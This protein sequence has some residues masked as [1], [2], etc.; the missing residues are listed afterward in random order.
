MIKKIINLLQENINRDYK[1]A[2]SI[3][4]EHTP[5]YLFLSVLDWI[6]NSTIFDITKNCINKV[7]T[8]YNWCRNASK[9]Q[10]FWGWKAIA[11]ILTG[12]A[13]VGLAFTALLYLMAKAL[14][15]TTVILLSIADTIIRFGM[16]LAHAGLTCATFP[17]LLLGAPM[18]IFGHFLEEK[19]NHLINLIGNKIKEIGVVLNKPFLFC[20]GKL[21]N[22][23][24]YIKQAW[25]LQKQRLID[26]ASFSAEKKELPKYNDLNQESIQPLNKRLTQAY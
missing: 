21:K 22:C 24:N 11:D 23:L 3:L 13:I 8:F 5:R 16:L 7:A 10:I 1:S 20:F 18:A 17:F 19:N 6:I 15:S 2:D 25:L 4:I 9:E 14:A 26:I 12:I